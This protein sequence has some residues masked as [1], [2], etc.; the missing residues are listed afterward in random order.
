LHDVT[1]H[2]FFND[3]S[4]FQLLLAIDLFKDSIQERQGQEEQAWREQEQGLEQ[5]LGQVQGGI[6]EQQRQEQEQLA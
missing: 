4:L 2:P 1:Q 6:Q 3:V 5:E